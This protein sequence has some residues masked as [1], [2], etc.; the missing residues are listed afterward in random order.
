MSNSDTV[1]DHYSTT[2]SLF[3]NC[4]TIR[5]L[6]HEFV[7]CIT[8]RQLHQYSS[9]VSLFDNCITSSTT[10][11]LFD[12]CIT[13]RQLYRLFYNYITSRQLY[14][15]STTSDTLFDI[16]ISLCRHTDTLVDYSYNCRSLI[17]LSNSNT[18]FE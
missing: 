14:H 13:S 7:T 9:T 2:V 11:S 8:S 6:Y 10:V 16:L 4:I 12:N 1:V 17:Q 5:Q 15:Y 18:V 3:V